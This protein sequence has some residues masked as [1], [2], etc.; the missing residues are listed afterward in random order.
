MFSAIV[1]VVL[2][3]CLAIVCI[4]TE[5]MDRF[6]G[7]S[8][9]NKKTS[10]GGNGRASGSSAATG[11]TK[12][13]LNEILRKR[14]ESHQRFVQKMNQQMEDVANEAKRATARCTAFAAQIE[15]LTKE[16]E[17]FRK[18]LEAKLAQIAVAKSPAPAQASPTMPVADPYSASQR[19]SVSPDPVPVP[20]TE[21]A[22]VPAP[23]KFVY[24]SRFDGNVL[25]E[26]D[27]REASFEIDLENGSTRFILSAELAVKRRSEFFDEVFDVKN[28]SIAMSSFSQKAAVA[29]NMG[30]GEWEVIQRGEIQF[31]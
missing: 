7:R 20:A 10:K 13:E 30:S 6:L 23:K 2:I 12:D 14:S 21:P 3:A 1:I 4:Q 18:D 22:P 26:C 24:A 29:R 17:K 27:K 28:A 11:I 8:A 5:Y 31:E 25:R 9:K 15:K 19:Q 16:N